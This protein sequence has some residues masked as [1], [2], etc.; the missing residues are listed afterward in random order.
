MNSVSHLFGAGAGGI[1]VTHVFAHIAH[2]SIDVIYAGCGEQLMGPR[3]NEI[4]LIGHAHGKGIHRDLTFPGAH[5][6]RLSGE[7]ELMG[8]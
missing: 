5:V 6:C 4:N 2:L 8:H 7:V 3:S 1:L